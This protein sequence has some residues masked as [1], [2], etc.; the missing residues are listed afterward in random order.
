MDWLDLLALQGTLKSLLQHHSSKASILRDLCSSLTFCLEDLSID[1]SGLLRSP[2]ITI[3][4]CISPFISVGIHFM[5]L[6]GSVLGAG[7][8]SWLMLDREELSWPTPS[9]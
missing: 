3:F 1:V 5:Y 9:F 6:S 4:L 8:P 7:L 2:T